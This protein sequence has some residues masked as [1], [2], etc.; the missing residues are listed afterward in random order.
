M[1]ESGHPDDRAGTP[2]KVFGYTGGSVTENFSLEAFPGLT[3]G[4]TEAAGRLW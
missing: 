4:T 1:N 3:H 2:V